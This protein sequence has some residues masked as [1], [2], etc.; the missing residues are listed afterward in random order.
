MFTRNYINLANPYSMVTIIMAYA[1]SYYCT[2]YLIVKY[3]VI[4]SGPS[5]KYWYLISQLYRNAIIMIVNPVFVYMISGSMFSQ[6]KLYDGKKVMLLQVN[7][8]HV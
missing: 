3:H 6:S 8:I 2:L 4:I 7:H 5:I 1:A